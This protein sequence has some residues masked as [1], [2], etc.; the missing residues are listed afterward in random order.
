MPNDN[1]AEPAQAIEPLYDWWLGLIRGVAGAPQAQPATG[2]DATADLPFPAGQVANAL[3]LTQQ[4][5]GPLYQNYLG[6]LSTHP[7]PSQAL[8]SFV[9]RAQGQM[10]KMSEQLAGA[11][12]SLSA[13]QA[14]MST[15]GW[16]MAS[17]PMAMLGRAAAPMAL[18]FERAYGGLADAF[19]L[20]PSRELADAARETAA[21]ALGKQQAQAEYLSL[22]VGALAKGGKGLL[23]QLEAM[24]RKGE[25]VD[26]LLGLMR[27]WSRAADAEMHTA[28]QS[29]KA[30]QAAAALVRA[31]NRSRRQRQRMVAIASEALNIPTRAEVDDAYREIQ[32]LKRE[33]R[34]L[35]KPLAPAAPAA[36]AAAPRK[37]VSAR[38]HGA[39]PR[40]IAAA[41]RG[42]KT[43]KKVTRS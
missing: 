27:L 12:Q 39:A 23:A 16:D 19:G 34:R 25:S 26:S 13:A 4:L 30:L 29:P 33:L 11:A 3:E 8:A 38:A 7:E 2:A 9:E 14:G 1:D 10:E 5:L 15:A 22:V 36:A 24:R 41:G 28:M 32:E 20:A 42:S 40:T 6:A 35:R 31:S 21:T 18:N 43:S 37:A 17:A